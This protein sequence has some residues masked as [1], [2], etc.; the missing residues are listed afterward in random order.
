MEIGLADTIKAL[1]G[2]LS[3]AM[4]EG[5]GHPVRLR[6]QSVKLD[7][8]VAVTASAEAGGGVKFW[9]LSAD[10]KASEA[11]STTHTVSLELTAETAD[12]GSVLTD[13]ARGARLED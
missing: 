6:V 2:E 1:R 10:G 12:G 11:T 7:M 8:Q 9:V 13:S 4:T 5:E 3:R